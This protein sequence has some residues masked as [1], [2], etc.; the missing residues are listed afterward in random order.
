MMGSLFGGAGG[1]RTVPRCCDMVSRR[2][3]PWGRS[4]VSD[5]LLD[6]SAGQLIVGQ[7]PLNGYS[8][9]SVHFVFRELGA[10]RVICSG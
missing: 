6:D 4:I 8:M 10:C 3:H 1:D 5:I 2:L 9:E 7:L